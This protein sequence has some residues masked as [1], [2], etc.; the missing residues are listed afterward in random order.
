MMFSLPIPTGLFAK[1]K[2]TFGVLFCL[3]LYFLAITP[4]GIYLSKHASQDGFTP[5]TISCALLLV[6]LT[7]ALPFLSRYYDRHPRPQLT[8]LTLASVLCALAASPAPFTPGTDVL[9]SSLYITGFLALSYALLRRWS[10]LLWFIWLFLPFTINLMSTRYQIRVDAHLVAEILG[11]SPQDVADF[12][13]FA[14]IG[15]FLAALLLTLGTAV[16]FYLILKHGDRKHLSVSGVCVILLSV[17]VSEATGD[18]LWDMLSYRAPEC[19]L[20][21]ANRARTIARERNSDL[22]QAT[23]QLPSAAIPTP[24][25]PADKQSR[26]CICLLHVGESVR[27]DHLSLFG[28]E[29]KTTPHLEQTENLIA[30]RD[31]VAAAPSTIPSTLAILTDAQT[32]ISHKEADVSL[33]PTCGGI[34]EIFHALDYAC[35]AFAVNENVG[36]TIGAL[37][38]ILLHDVFAAGADSIIAMPKRKLSHSQIPQILETIQ[39]EQKKHI[40]CF[41]NN[42]GSHL[43]FK[44][45]D[46]GNAP[47]TPASWRAYNR[48]PEKNPEAAAMVRNTYDCTIHFTDEYIHSLLSQLK[49]KSFI[50]IYV[51]DHGEYLGDQ[52]IWV[53]S[54]DKQTFFS[55]PVCQVPFLIITSQEFEEQNPHIKQALE[56]LREHQNMSIGHGHIFHTLLG[57]FGI[58]TP[59]YNESLDLC[60]DKV[61]PYSGPHPSRHGQSADGKKWY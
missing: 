17:A 23:K 32:D 39:A 25:L 16:V 44:D 29:R 30:F 8:V 46:S 50:Y 40:F 37:Y 9:L 19:R 59:Y 26:E 22:I 6:F 52:G 55:S 45:Y 47:F 53:R 43:P 3:L 33:K 13:G 51:S 12:T 41:I 60:S 15:L 49:G 58:Q 14:N 4:C 54:G 7:A 11:A 56:R 10:I 1:L 21:E 27:S 48:K 18:R 61:Q 35:Y 42:R 38:E 57:L 34:M 20:I 36:K 2:A 24:I 31:C 5:Y 28:Y